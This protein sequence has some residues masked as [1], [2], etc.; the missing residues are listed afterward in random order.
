[1]IAFNVY[2]LLSHPVRWGCD[3]EVFGRK[4]KHGQLV[5][6]DKHGFLVRFL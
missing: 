5:H 4:I 1:M 3:V 6:A 2:K